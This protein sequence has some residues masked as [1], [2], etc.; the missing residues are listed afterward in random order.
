MLPADSSAKPTH[1]KRQYLV[2]DKHL[3][4]NVSVIHDA[5]P[6]LDDATSVNPK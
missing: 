2:L 5:S 6:Y 3:L 1:D 4:G